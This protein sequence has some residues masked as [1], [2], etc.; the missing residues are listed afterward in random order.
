MSHVLPI[1]LALFTSTKGHFG[2][3]DLYKATLTHWDRQ[4][5]LGLFGARVAHVKV[6]PGDEEIAAEMMADLTARGFRVLQTV[7]DW[8]RGLSH[9]ASYLSDMV[10]VSKERATY[11]QPYFL[12][13]ED[14]SP[15]VVHDGNLEDLLLKS[16]AMLETDHEMVTARV[17]RRG[18]D[19]GPT[20]D[21]GLIDER[22][23]W[24][25]DTNFQPL[26]MRSLDYYRLCIALET[27][28]DACARV[29]CERLW[30]LILDS[31][32][33]SPYK[34]LVWEIDH[35]ETVHLGTQDYATKLAALKL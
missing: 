18:D 1:T 10:T 19:R 28:P 12:L 34:H 4:I 27:N 30:R 21:L 11:T 16:C 14:D 23:F 31:F 6:T 15:V 13:V 9:G 35:A 33:R 17:M 5:P 29:Q 22:F 32:S 8:H 25:V 26:V 3:R 2:C 20:V 24:S 7:A